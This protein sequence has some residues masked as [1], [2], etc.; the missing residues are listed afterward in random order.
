MLTYLQSFTHR[1]LTR[2]GIANLADLKQARTQH[3]HRVQLAIAEAHA[4]AEQRLLDTQTALSARIVQEFDGRLERAI[5]AEQPGF[6]RLREELQLRLDNAL[7]VFENRL[8]DLQD[9]APK[10]HSG[11]PNEALPGI[12]KAPVSSTSAFK[13]VPTLA[14]D[15][16]TAA[17]HFTLPAGEAGSSEL[18]GALLD[19][20][21]QVR[22]SGEMNS[23]LPPALALCWR[24][25]VGQGAQARD[26]LM[27]FDWG[28]TGFPLETI[29]WLNANVGAVACATTHA[30]KVLRDHGCTIPLATIGL[31]ID[32][33]DRQARDREYL[34]PGK[35]FRFLH[36]SAC[37]S[38]QA[39][40]TLLDAFGQVFA[41]DD[42]VSLV[43]CSTGDVA[44]S[45]LDEIA[46]RRR[47][48]PAYPDVALVDGPLSDAELKALYNQCQV[49]VSAGRAEGFSA[50]IS[51]A[52]L[53]GLPVVATGWGGHLDYCNSDTAWLV[54][55]EFARAQSPVGVLASAWAE[56]L[57]EALE[58]ALWFAYRADPA[59]RFSKGWS[60]RRALIQRYEWKEVALRLAKLAARSKDRSDADRSYKAPVGFVT[61]WNSK[62]GIASYVGHLL[63]ETAPSD[64][65]IFADKGSALL[66]ADANNCLRIWTQGP[67]IHNDLSEIL[68]N[69]RKLSINSLVV[70]FNFGFYNP[71]GFHEFIERALAHGVSVIVEMHSTVAPP[72]KILPVKLSDFAAALNLCQKVLAHSPA[73][74][75]RL[76][77]AGVSDNVTI[78][79]LGI[80]A[81][82]KL[83]RKRSP[84]STPEI[85]SFGFALPNKGLVELVE[86][87]S[88]LREDGIETRLTMWNSEY[89]APASAAELENIRATIARL[90]LS[91]SVTVNSEYL[92]DAE[93]VRV[94]SKA[95]LIVNPYQDTG[96]SSSAAVRFALAS[97]AP[98]MV[99]PL[100]IFSELGE[101]VFRS[102]GI[103]PRAL[104]D[105]IAKTLGNLKTQTREAETVQSAAARWV[106][107]HNAHLLGRRLMRLAKTV[108][109][110]PQRGF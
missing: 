3:E 76:K 44:G 82:D 50:A 64:F 30:E 110:A 36:V 72:T 29:E 28:D 74:M 57:P 48:N 24:L 22:T 7:A 88:L 38:D 67:L 108:A 62:C 81:A 59:E 49:F 106:G 95:D 31:G 53:S 92:E 8:T 12:L 1:F 35:A 16:W 15:D 42:E 54:D 96:E 105:G 14:T 40:P 6:V 11:A 39:L 23:K 75:S 91:N 84:R 56:P 43:I 83:N 79:P 69:L 61:S 98:V 103:N 60:G 66:S 20:G 86:A 65:V 2:S 77:A 10:P 94:L 32:E 4:F 99:T 58:E 89:P 25:R 13:A 71:T 85:A 87:I 63:E 70:Q 78:F 80:L 41:Q 51:R 90:G 104:A 37:G 100:P 21:H 5:S 55:F 107:Q 45:L 46:E 9:Q 18:A 33:W 19:L 97:R 101:A 26:V 34:A 102:E 109:V 73:D 52:F 17:L 93:C 47:S 27:G 68:P